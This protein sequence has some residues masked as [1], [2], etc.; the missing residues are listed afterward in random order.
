MPNTTSVTALWGKYLVSVDEVERQSG[1]DLLRAVR[2]DV[3]VVIER[4]VA[5]AP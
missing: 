2:D 1:Y 3:E 4:R 5:R